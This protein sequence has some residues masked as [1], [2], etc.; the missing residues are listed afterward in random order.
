MSVGK[1]IEDIIE[2]LCHRSFFADFTIR[3]PKYYK[4]GGLEKEAADLLVVFNETL[5]AIQ[6]KSKDVSTSTTPNQVERDRLSKT[7]EGAIRQF[8]AL[9]EAWNNPA[10]NS[11]VNGRGVE[12]PFDRSCI[13]NIVWVVVL[14]PIWDDDNISAPRLR[15]NNTCYP[16]GPI[17]VHLFTL[18]QFSLL[19][20]MLNTL[21]DFLVFLDARWLLHGEKLI[22]ADSDPVDEWALITFERKRFI[23]IVDNRICTDISGLLNRHQI[24]VERLERQ[25]KPS[26]FVDRL[27]EMLCKAIGS[28]EPV[29]PRFNLLAEPNSLKGYSMT[30]PYFAMLNRDQ[31]SR[32]VEFLMNR[33]MECEKKGVGFRAF[34]FDDHSTEAYLVLAVR[35]AREER[36]IGL[37]NIARGV[38][39]KLKVKTV[40][41]IVVSHNWPDSQECDVGIVDVSNLKA[42]EQLIE[43]TNQTFGRIRRAKR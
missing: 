34:K 15:F 28:R 42:G 8:R 12:V 37:V 38:G 21:P 11:F 26:Y 27:I 3:S 35:A 25:E 18:E 5:L 16:D 6:I 33:V 10:F 4:S 31:R 2:N 22:P 1:S 32:L 43:M 17:A 13:K 14:A 24:S 20:T 39:F 7:V 29:D 9:T 30:I 36:R 19:L 40:I 23:G 41:G